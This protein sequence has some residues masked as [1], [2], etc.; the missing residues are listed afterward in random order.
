MQEISYV[1]TCLCESVCVFVRTGAH[2]HV[3]LCIGN[4]KKTIASGMC[5]KLAKQNS[6]TSSFQSK[7]TEF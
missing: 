4:A 5:T 6:I 7:S 2:I 1:Y 3:Y